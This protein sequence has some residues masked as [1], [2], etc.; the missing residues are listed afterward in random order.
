[1]KEEAHAVQKKHLLSPICPIGLTGQ[2]NGIYY[3]YAEDCPTHTPFLVQSEVELQTGCR[4]DN[5]DCRLLFHGGGPF[6]GDED[7]TC[8]FLKDS[9]LRV[10]GLAMPLPSN[11][12]AWPGPGTTLVGWE[13]RDFLHEGV[14]RRVRLFSL[15]YHPPHQA[16]DAGTN[17]VVKIG[18][19]Q[20][21]DDQPAGT[22]GGLVVEEHEDGDCY[23]KLRAGLG[24]HYHLLVV[25]R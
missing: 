4:P 17:R 15:H 8:R 2:M 25:K 10:N 20:E 24:R 1:M 22:D 19:G 11:G 13:D 12:S 9:T 6:G 3:W 5:Q 16:G 7:P 23:F 21:L 14:R 18:I